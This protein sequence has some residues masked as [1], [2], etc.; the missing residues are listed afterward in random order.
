MATAT[1]TDSGR[2]LIRDARRGLLTD[3]KI[4]Y[5]AIGTTNT[6]PAAGQTQLFAETFRKI[7]TVNSSGAAGVG[8]FTLYLAPGEAVGTNI[9]EVGWFAG[10]GATGTAN[11]GVMVARGLYAH[12]K[13]ASE[14]I[15]VDFTLTE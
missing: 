15:Q 3:V 13:A 1:L 10:S 12:T 6:A 2:S 11:S 7:M 8:I 4:K 5:V 14:S 9:Q